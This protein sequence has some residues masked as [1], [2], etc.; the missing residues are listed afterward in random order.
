M[1]VPRGY[2]VVTKRFSSKEERRRLVAAV[3]D[4]DLVDAPNVGFEN[5][6][7]YFHRDGHGLAKDE[8]YGL[9]AFLNSEPIDRYFRQFNG[10]A[11][12]NANDL[13]SLRYPR[14]EALR[15]L[16]GSQLRPGSEELEQ[17]VLRQ[18]PLP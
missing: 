8:A 13:R 7:N 17:A 14:R 3:Y 18:C 2:Y 9:A 12:V 6:I 1:L 10:H 4:P 5:H 15:D 11:Q 16:G